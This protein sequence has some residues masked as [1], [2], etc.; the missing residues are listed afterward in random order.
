MDPKTRSVIARCGVGFALWLGVMGLFI[1][2][3]PG[4]EA[5]WFGAA[6]A[7]SALGLMSPNWRMRALAGVLVIG[8]TWAAWEGYERGQ[9]YQKWLQQQEWLRQ[10][11]AVPGK[12]DK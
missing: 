9:Q 11:K 10:P 5:G 7:G 4:A 6:A 8:L 2:F 1:S 12:N 3:V